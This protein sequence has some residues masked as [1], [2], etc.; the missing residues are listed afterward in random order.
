MRWGLK[1]GAGGE[2]SRTPVSFQHSSVIPGELASSL[3]ILAL[4][5]PPLPPRPC[6]AAFLLFVPTFDG[7]GRGSLGRLGTQSSSESS[8]KEL[9]RKVN[10]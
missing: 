9:R 6:P 3:L 7:V 8:T 10:Q 5:L 4:P 1:T 2:V